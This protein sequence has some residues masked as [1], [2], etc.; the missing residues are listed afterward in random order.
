MAV[1]ADRQSHEDQ[2]YSSP[3]VHC[4]CNDPG[5]FVFVSVLILAI[6]QDQAL[7]ASKH[8]LVETE[9]KNLVDN[10]EG[11]PEAELKTL[12]DQTVGN[13]YECKLWTITSFFECLGVFAIPQRP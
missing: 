1:A 3:P 2:E 7:V 13:D 6:I 10:A 8:F 12:P 9:N 11:P 5:T 4:K